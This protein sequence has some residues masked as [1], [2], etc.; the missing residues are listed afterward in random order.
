MRRHLQTYKADS[1]S[2]AIYRT[3]GTDGIGYLVDMPN[4]QGN[5]ETLKQALKDYQEASSAKKSKTTTKGKSKSVAKVKP[6]GKAVT[7]KTDSEDT[8]VKA[9]K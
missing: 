9:N 8:K 3:T 2:G 7:E 5:G 4:G 6:S 1:H